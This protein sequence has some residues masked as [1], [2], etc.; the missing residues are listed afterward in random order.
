MQRGDSAAPGGCFQLVSVLRDKA[1]NEIG[2]I[3]VEGSR[4]KAKE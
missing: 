3:S 4:M 2:E 1:V